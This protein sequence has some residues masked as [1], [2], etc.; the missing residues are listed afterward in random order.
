MKE[1]GTAF[2]LFCVFLLFIWLIFLYSVR[3]YWFFRIVK[4][5]KRSKLRS[6]SS[7]FSQEDENGGVSVEFSVRRRHSAFKSVLIKRKKHRREEMLTL[8]GTLL[9]PESDKLLVFVHKEGLDRRQAA[10]KCRLF[11]ENGWSVLAFDQ[12]AHGKS[13]G[14]RSTL[15][16]CE[17]EDLAR[18]A[19]EAAGEK[20]Y[21]SVGFYGVGC[22]AAAAL[23]SLDR[24]PQVDFVIAEDVYPSYVEYLRFLIRKRR[25]LRRIDGLIIDFLLRNCEKYLGLP[26]RDLCPLYAAMNHPETALYLTA[27]GTMPLTLIKRIE[28]N[29][30]PS[31][32]T[33]FCGSPDGW[34]AYF[35]TF[36]K[37]NRKRG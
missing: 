25:I 14:K 37:K 6:C 31:S 21:R 9:N 5:T 24:A 13:D 35:D 23:L 8:R 19:G 15:G 32:E 11:A 2:I 1:M 26:L 29:R 34:E 20:K 30:P 18:I 10:E 3:M 17:S 28:E 4:A 7:S 12:R 16:Y 27:G 36:D 33:V 22:G